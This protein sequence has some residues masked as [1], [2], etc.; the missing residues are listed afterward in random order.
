[1]TEIQNKENDILLYVTNLTEE[2]TSQDSIINILKHDKIR[3][4]KMVH[5]DLPNL[6]VLNK[7]KLYLAL[8]DK[9]VYISKSVNH[10]RF[11]QLP[12]Q[13]KE[14]MNEILKIN[15]KRFLNK[16]IVSYFNSFKLA[17]CKYKFV[18]SLND[19]KD[20]TNV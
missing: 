9:H 18:L 12:N 14:L 5:E 15:N 7:Q 20:A 19:Q 11:Y 6:L 10:E 17:F 4:A 13:Y 2:Y 3:I 16:W 8:I 1:M